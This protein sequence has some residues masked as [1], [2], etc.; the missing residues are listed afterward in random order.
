MEEFFILLDNGS[1]SQISS[2]SSVWGSIPH[3]RSKS[4]FVPYSLNICYHL[5]VKIGG[6]FFLARLIELKVE[7]KCLT[8][9]SNDYGLRKEIQGSIRT[10]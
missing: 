10:C 4:K 7:F 6:F 3:P 1:S 9:K 5:S 8:R 2:R